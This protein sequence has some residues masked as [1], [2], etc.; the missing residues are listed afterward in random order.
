[1]NGCWHHRASA[2]ALKNDILCLVDEVKPGSEGHHIV[3][4]TTGKPRYRVGYEDL[5]AALAANAGPAAAAAAA[6]A[7]A[8]AGSSEP[9]AEGWPSMACVA[10]VVGAVCTGLM[11]MRYK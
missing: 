3:K 4:G 11:M 10:V 5:A 6:A 7:T 1:M 8:A 2:A 9:A